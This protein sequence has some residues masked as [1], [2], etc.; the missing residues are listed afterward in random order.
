MEG[1]VEGRIV[2]FVI[3][4]NAWDKIICRPAII[5]R[6]WETD[7]QINLQVFLDGTNDT[8]IVERIIKH[9]KVHHLDELNYWV[10]VVQYSDQKEPGTWHWPER[11]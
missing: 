10:S 7:S 1:L 2:H 5:V 8:E 3:G 4:R 11:S 6:V 9:G